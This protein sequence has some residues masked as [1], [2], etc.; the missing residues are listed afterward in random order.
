MRIVLSVLLLL[1]LLNQTGARAE[2]PLVHSLFT[3]H[4]VVQRGIEVPVWGWAEQGASITVELG[5]KQVTTTANAAGRWIAKIGPFDA[6]GPHELVV[7]GTRT[8]TIND[9]LIGDVW[10]CS[11]QSNMEWPVSNVNQAQ[12][13]ISAANYPQVRLFTVPRRTAD[14]PQETV[15]GTWQVCTPESVPS[16][17]AVGYFFGKELHQELG[18]PIGLIHSSWGGTLAE[19]WTSAEAL[20]T[21]DDF[22]PALVRTRKLFDAIKSGKYSYDELLD[23]W[24]RESDPGS[25][26]GI[27]WAEPATADDDWLTMTLPRLWEEAGLPDYDG[28]CWFRRE[29]TLAESWQGRSA[30]L[31]LGPIDDQDT[32]WI[33]GKQVGTT[34]KW[35]EP[36]RYAV[37]KGILKP[38]SNI[39]A[40]RVLDT[41]GGGGLYGQPKQMALS[42]G[43][44]MRVELSGDWKYRASANLKDLAPVPQPL[45]ENANALTVLYNGMIAPL[46]PFGIK[47]AIWYQGESNAGRGLQYRTLLPLMIRDWRNRFGVGDFPFLVVQLANFLQEQTQPVEPGWALLREAQWLTAKQDE[48]VGLAVTTDIGNATDVHPR[49]KQDVG[50]RLVLQ[51]L[52]IAYGQELI[53]AGPEFESLAIDGPE[54]RATF[55]NVGDGLVAHGDKLTG[56]ALAGDDGRFEWAQ[57]EIRDGTVVLTAEGVARPVAVRYNWA[58]N[59]IG[60]LFNK[61]G[62]PAAPFRTDGDA[63]E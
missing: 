7:K 27:G 45:G 4:M 30:T 19:A 10:I 60:N 44:T 12:A 40:V 24:W 33:N 42:A 18:V 36:R 35:D 31:E 54:A 52:T 50:H 21:M 34:W 53:A 41:G 56:F 48:R 61:N 14:E 62:L 11:G 32:V 29:I 47:G 8:V 43:D 51:A 17:S 38:G 22:R 23:Q 58:N 37:S 20:E 2:R 5:G 1:P 59:P 28:V 55:S 9:V 6:G 49:N 46:V 13:E 25:R 16:F 15:E 63:P 26:T 3:D 39:I 57:A